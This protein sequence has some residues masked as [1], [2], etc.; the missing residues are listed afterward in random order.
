VEPLVG[1]NPI[2][3]LGPDPKKFPVSRRKGNGRMSDVE[4]HSGLIHV[5]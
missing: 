5:C 2:E 3:L 4:E 1:D